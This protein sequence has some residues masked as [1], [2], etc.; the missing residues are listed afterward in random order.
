VSRTGVRVRP[1]TID[2]VPGL[3]SLARSLDLNAGLFSGRP[4]LDPSAEHLGRRFSEL[5]TQG[6]RHL[7]VAVDEGGAVVGLLAARR[8]YIGAIDPTPVL[9]VSHLMVSTTHRR[10]GV[11]RALLAGSVHLAEEMGIDHVLATATS[12]SREGNRYLA[13]LGFK[14]LVTQRLAA[15]SGL[16][17]TLGMTD[18]GGRVAV[19]RR[20]RLGRAPRAGLAGPAGAMTGAEGA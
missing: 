3:V 1:A 16:R 7:L 12:Q 19:L 13:R 15:T 8:D 20:A 17:R 4:L 5:V 14:P 11:G 18:L 9:H 2:D 10:R 6:E